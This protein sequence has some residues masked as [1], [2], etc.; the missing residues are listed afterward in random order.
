MA[1]LIITN[2]FILLDR[3]GINSTRDNFYPQ[4]WG[5]RKGNFLRYIRVILYCIYGK[6]YYDI[7]CALRRQ[8]KSARY[9]AGSRDSPHRD[10][11]WR[12]VYDLLYL[13]GVILIT[14]I[15]FIRATQPVYNERFITRSTKRECWDVR[16]GEGKGEKEEFFFIY[17][18]THFKHRN[19]TVH[20]KRK[21][22]FP[23]TVP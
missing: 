3:T 23:P 5:W 14:I 10:G 21:R 17:S 22:C 4:R 12:F 1:W 16:R 8:Q 9:R 13:H 20:L 19:Q 7:S 2:P 6:F 11:P 18:Y 15:I